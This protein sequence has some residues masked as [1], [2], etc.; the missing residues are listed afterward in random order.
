[1]KKIFLSLMILFVGLALNAQQYTYVSGYTKSNGTYVEGHYRTL[2]N[3]TRDDNWSRIGNVN[4]FTGVAGTKPG[5]SYYSNISNYPSYSSEIRISNLNTITYSIPSISSQIAN[6]YSSF[7][8]PQSYSTYS[9]PI[10][11]PTN[12]FG[13]SSIFSSPIN[14]SGSSKYWY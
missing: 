14:L 9:T 11:Y 12:I 10:S 5:D 4:P 3:S 13:N 6:S 8:T 2:P 7:L 1:M